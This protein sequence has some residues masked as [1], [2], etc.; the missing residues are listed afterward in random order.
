MADNSSQSSLFEAA[1]PETA[2]QE[3]VTPAAMEAVAQNQGRLIAFRG[4][5]GLFALGHY[6]LAWRLV[7]EESVLLVD[8]ANLINLPLML[9]LTRG[10]QADARTL[11]SRI[12]LSRAFTVHQLEAVIGD[13]LEEAMKKYQSRLCFI[14]GLLDPFHDEG[15]PQ[16]EAARI[17]G[18]VLE[19]LRTLANQGCRV[20]VLAPDP[21]VPVMKRK[22]LASMMTQAADRNFVLMNEKGRLVLLD[23][24]QNTDGKHWV[25]PA[26]QV[27]MHRYSPR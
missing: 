15:L 22:N 9:R 6:L 10:L 27:R 24:T 21:P 7:Q 19:K 4:D 12:H 20:V 17:F 16:W 8:G 14:S 23:Q 13:R 3:I 26:I 11:L 2:W 5:H 25:L 1:E 18:R